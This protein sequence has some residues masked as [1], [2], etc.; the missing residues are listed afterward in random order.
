MTGLTDF[1]TE[2]AWAHLLLAW[3]VVIDDAYQALER[4]FT[5][6]RRRGPAPRFRDSEVITVALFID[7][8]FHGHEALG[9]H[10]LRQYHPDLFPHLLADSTFNAR[11]TQ[12]APLIEQVRR[13]LLLEW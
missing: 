8:I 12:L 10:F 13:R 1:I 4:Y 2:A 11:R 5:P 7:T 3:F 9:L 6:W